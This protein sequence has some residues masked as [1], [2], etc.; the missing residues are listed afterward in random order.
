MFTGS[1]V[2]RFYRKCQNVAAILDFCDLAVRNIS[3]FIPLN[4]SRLDIIKY[5]IQL[6]FYE[7][8]IKKF[9]RLTIII[10]R[11]YV[12]FDGSHFKDGPENNFCNGNSMG[13]LYVQSRHLTGTFQI[14][15]N[16]YAFAL[17]NI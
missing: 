8:S 10:V 3:F 12:I 14:V 13:I 1:K 2:M 17:N 6:M 7:A 5:S 15:K 16:V 4:S 9:G 11:K